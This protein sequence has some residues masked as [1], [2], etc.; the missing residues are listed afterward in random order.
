MVVQTHISF[1]PIGGTDSVLGFGTTP[2]IS[3]WRLRNGWETF[4]TAQTLPVDFSGNEDKNSRYFCQNT[5]PDAKSNCC[6]KTK[7][8]KDFAMKC[9]NGHKIKQ[10]RSLLSRWKPSMSF[11]SGMIESQIQLCPLHLSA[12]LNNLS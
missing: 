6:S 2:L 5:T 4:D 9:P 10:C 1:L 7:P 3:D 12:F 8:A 11:R